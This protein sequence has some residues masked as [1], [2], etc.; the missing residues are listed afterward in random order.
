MLVATI[1]HA[2]WQLSVISLTVYVIKLLDRWLGVI[3]L[4]QMYD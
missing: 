4:N 3:W 2:I 1:I